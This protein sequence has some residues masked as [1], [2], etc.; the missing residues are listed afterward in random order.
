MRQSVECQNVLDAEG[1]PAGGY[2]IGTGIDICWQNGPLG[3][4]G[5][6]E[7]IEPNG[8]FVEDV[9]AVVHQRIDHYQNSGFACKENERAMACLMAALWFLDKRTRRRVAAQT[10]GTHEGS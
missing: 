7:R 3:R 9:I 5:T 2:A 1:R 8:A 4:V 10:E 6:D